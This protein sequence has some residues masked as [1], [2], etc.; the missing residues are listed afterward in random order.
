ML[1]SDHSTHRI[2]LIHALSDS[3]RPIH[4]AF[5]RH[6]PS[7]RYFDLLDTSLS[8]DLATEGKLSAPMHERFLTLGRYAAAQQGM[9]GR[10]GAILFTC[11]AF[12]PAIDGVKAA[13]SIPVLR[14]N[15]AAF[16]AAL[17]AGHRIALLVTFEPSGAALRTE[18][19]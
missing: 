9:G 7:A 11:S 6:W 8:A 3:V 1:S 2:V 12:G 15:E 4:A 19:L 10:T 17:K 5:Q 13:L 18:L 16:T 14:P